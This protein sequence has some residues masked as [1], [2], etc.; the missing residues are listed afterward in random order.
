MTFTDEEYE[1][2]G[3]TPGEIAYDKKRRELELHK[4]RAYIKEIRGVQLHP[5]EDRGWWLNTAIGRKGIA[6]P[7]K[8]MIHRMHTDAWFKALEKILGVS[9]DK[10]D[11]FIYPVNENGDYGK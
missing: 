4:G 5:I 9:I 7:K 10:D 11:D 6:E 2:L 3:Y 1:E 8:R